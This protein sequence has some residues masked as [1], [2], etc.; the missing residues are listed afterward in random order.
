M[1][2]LTGKTALVTG[3]ASGIGLRTAERFAAEGA[4]VI[5]ADKSESGLAA[6]LDKVRALGG[7][8][9]SVLLDVTQELGWIDAA[10][11]MESEFGAL[12]ALVNNAGHG[13]F[14]S[15]LDTSLADW[16]AT[17][18]V[19]LDSVFLATKHC[20]PLLARSGKASIINVSSIRGLVAAPGTGSYCASKA[21]V[22]LF[23]KVTALE[24]AA[25]GN[26]VR[27]NSVHP[28]HVETPLT[29]QALADPARRLALIDRIPFGRMAAP[30]EIA[31]VIVFLASD[32]SSFMT[33][34]EVV[35]D[36]GFT[37]Q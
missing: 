18:A 1:G 3:A 14:Q 10:R 9:S 19:N 4:N 26:G 31:D 32:A 24:C 2:C 16:R 22:A 33:G 29:T 8:H 13:T 34:S 12:D 30:Q 6:T 36:G 28:G 35:V 21:G 17:I 25:A 20:L 7:R 37:A 27:A 5:L 11:Q 23:T 15:I